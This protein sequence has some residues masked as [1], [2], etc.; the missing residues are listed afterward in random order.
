MKFGVLFLLSGLSLLSCGCATSSSSRAAHPR[1]HEA[2][3]ANAVLQFA[4][5]DYTFMLKPRYEDHGFLNRLPRDRVGP[6]LDS[7]NVTQRDLAVVVVGWN[8][9]QQELAELS[10]EWRVILGG[11]GFH[12]VVLLKSNGSKEL[13]G[14]FIVDDSILSDKETGT[15]ARF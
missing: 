2:S 10:H 3:S 4:S 14:A 15:A 9:G 8:R 11:C 7:L 6:V 1:F 12:R 5:W 13:N